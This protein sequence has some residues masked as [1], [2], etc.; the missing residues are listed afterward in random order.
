MFFKLPTLVIDI[1]SSS[2]KMLEVSGNETKKLRKFGIA[3]LPPETV[4]NG[5][6]RNPEALEETLSKLLKSLGIFT[7]RRRVIF[8]LGG[9]ATIIKRIH[10]TTRQSLAELHQ[11]INFEA[12]QAFQHDVNDLYY[13]YHIVQ[14][15]A[16]NVDTNVI[17]AGAKRDLVE[18]YIGVIKAVGLKIGVIDSDV[19]AVANMFEYN[20][21]K[22]KG[23]TALA[24][25]GFASTQVVFMHE[26]R[27][28]FSREIAFGGDLYTRTLS[29]KLGILRVLAEDA[30]ISLA[31]PGA[32]E[33][34]IQTIIREVND[35][36]VNEIQTT[37]NFFFQSGDAPMDET[38]IANIFL[39]GGG[40]NILG[41]D[42]AIAA[43]LQKP[44]SI[45][46]PFGKFVIPG[47]EKSALAAAQRSA[48]G[49]A[50][51]LA[52]RSVGEARG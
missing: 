14:T 34:D 6:I 44:V 3:P 51:G 42:A 24:N 30:K 15:N 38:T 28:L 7:F 26:N 22:T 33:G 52:L 13:D 27:F 40:A 48:Y 20:T 8:A 47:G 31:A 19:L 39:T 17:L 50:V 32:S 46:D 16:E 37:I 5:T 49:V 2:V 41:L 43:V 18:Q 29:E 1:G 25:I 35:Q 4:V 12:E 21:E 45:I 10:L 36:F 11:T 23:I 9:S